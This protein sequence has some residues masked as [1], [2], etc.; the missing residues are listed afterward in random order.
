M[1]SSTI[2]PPIRWYNSLNFKFLLVQTIVLILI[3]GGTIGVL[4]FFERP[5]LISQRQ[6]LVKQVGD[7]IVVNLEGRIAQTETLAISLAELGDGLEKK[8]DLLM[9]IVP[10]LLDYEISD[11]LV[12]GGGIWSEPFALD[13]KFYG[14]SL[15]WG[16]NAKGTLNNMSD[17]SNTEHPV[18]HN[19]H[20]YVSASRRLPHEVFWSNAYMGLYSAELVVTCST[21]M[22][23]DGSILGVATV[24]LRL[25]G[26]KDFFDRSVQ[27]IG[28]YVFA[29]DRNNN[30]L[31]FPNES[32]IKANRNRDQSDKST[33]FIYANELGE[34]EILFK[35]ISSAL[36]S[37]NSNIV[38]TR[39]IFL[40]ND[41]LLGIPVM[42]SIFHIGKTNW[43]VVLV[44]PSSHFY[45]NADTVIKKVSI[46]I[47]AIGSLTLVFLFW[48][49]R[50]LITKPINDMA[51]VLVEAE[52][53]GDAHV[54]PLD[55]STQH[56][57][58]LFAKAFNQKANDLKFTKNE[59]SRKIS[60]YTKVKEES[61]IIEENL[62]ITLDFICE[63]VIVTGNEN[64]IER[65]NSAGSEMLDISP[66]DA[67]GTSTSEILTLLDA[68]SKIVLDNPV[69]LVL[70]SGNIISQYYVILRKIS[71]KEI[72][73]SYGAAPVFDANHEI[74]SV[75]L[76]C[77]DITKQNHFQEQ[78][79]EAQKM[80]SIGQL[81][82]G[83]AHDFN[84]M[85]GGILGSLELIELK[86]GHI[87]DL[88]KRIDKSMVAA[89]K[90][91][92]LTR[93]LLAFSR[94]AVVDSLPID[95]HNTIQQSIELLSYSTDKRVLVK[96]NFK[97]SDS[98]ILGDP[99]QIQNVILNL[100]IN[101]RDA[102][103]D[104][105]EL[106]FST[107]NQFLDEAFCTNSSH[108][109]LPGNYLVIS[110][111]DTG[112][113]ME[114]EVSERI[115]E[116]FFTTKE[117][118]KGTGLGLAAVS[119]IILHHKGFIQV[120][121]VLNQG[122]EFKIYLPVQEI[123]VPVIDKPQLE[124]FRVGSG[125]LLLVDDESLIRENLK[126]LMPNFGYDVLTA[127]DGEECLRIYK[128]EGAS[129]DLV[130]LDMVMPKMGGKETFEALF[131]MDPNI[132]IILASG[133]TKHIALNKMLR[134]KSYG[135]VQKP[136]KVADLKELIEKILNPHL[137]S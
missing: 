18:H 61:Q 105:G 97:S 111:S 76:V 137:A 40:E 64:H 95:I 96:T 15:F 66:Q 128:S 133:Y 11:P 37:M 53:E 78:F 94:K 12:V 74:V 62:R 132:K 124:P 4:F 116:P 69:Q 90:A 110:V 2:L 45:T 36:T 86:H 27:A 98:I 20:W 42:V 49:L 31:T 47:I 93:N 100:G 115:F 83:I 113:G 118:G 25:K 63:A 77:R 136:F 81:A 114:G 92:D 65:I 8:P 84:N 39:R 55:E 91:A 117:I 57:L 101:A 46:Y 38:E 104:G 30:F 35:P 130:I 59:L 16:R 89:K 103:S 50:Y 19:E 87:I 5:A 70:E 72:I 44:T 67:N 33:E 14:R 7:S 22:Y 60:E 119:S 79:I 51:S 56:E 73:I 71:G 134:D 3:V 28:G 102:M 41:I 29:V 125:R 24:D 88:K 10:R 9:K 107:Y 127:V 109:I 85:L 82:G 52:K 131:G 23:R 54:H 75:V 6:D 34:K 32:L 112:S 123:Q 126:E 80:E 43:K 120:E 108:E 122:S 106:L 21:P 99:I 135:F 1:L 13:E 26:V 121:S 48:V 58:S 17:Y 68:E 129:I